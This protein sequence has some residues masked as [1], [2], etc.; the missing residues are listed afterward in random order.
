MREDGPGALAGRHPVRAVVAVG[1]GP[2]A[3]A[4]LLRDHADADAAAL[5]RDRA[6]QEAAVLAARVAGRAEGRA[7]V[8]EVVRYSGR[9]HLLSL[10]DCFRRPTH[11]AD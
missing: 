1:A 11:T 6:R 5:A 7:R 2:D 3:A 8:P 4:D 9:R 10:G